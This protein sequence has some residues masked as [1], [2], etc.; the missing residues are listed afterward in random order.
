MN[1]YTCSHC[2]V[3]MTSKG[4][5]HRQFLQVPIPIQMLLSA[6]SITAEQAKGYEKGTLDTVLRMGPYNAPLDKQRLVDLHDALPNIIEY[7]HLWLCKHDWVYNREKSE[8]E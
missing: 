7:S 6:L 2:N 1:H 8:Q 3:G 4:P 5:G